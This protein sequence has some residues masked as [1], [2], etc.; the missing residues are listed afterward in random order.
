MKNQVLIVIF[1]I[2]MCAK[3][4]YAARVNYLLGVSAA[5]DTNVNLVSDNEEG[6]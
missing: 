6:E 5:H 1:L 3:N 4:V 2:G